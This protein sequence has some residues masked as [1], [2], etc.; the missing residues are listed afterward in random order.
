MTY[1]V[2]HNIDGDTYVDVLSAQE[3]TERLNENYYGRSVEF[4][5]TVS[6]HDTNY[7]GDG[8]LIIKGE[9]V[10]PK[11]VETVTKYEV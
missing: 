5:D 3:L 9:I 1:F 2:I 11:P 8:H 4:L 7:W 10:I 6:N